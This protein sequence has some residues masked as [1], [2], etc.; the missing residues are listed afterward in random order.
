MICQAEF[1]KRR[2]VLHV[3]KL[4]RSDHG[5]WLVIWERCLKIGRLIWFTQNTV[6]KE[7][8]I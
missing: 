2:D 5:K 4:Y 6:E 7:I 8:T 3:G 1:W